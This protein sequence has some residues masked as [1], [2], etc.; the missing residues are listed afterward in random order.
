MNFNFFLLVSIYISISHRFNTFI[1]IL[2]AT[3]STGS[4]FERVFLYILVAKSVAKFMLL[5]AEFV[6]LSI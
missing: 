5:M 1:A 4:D 6:P 3:L 2:L